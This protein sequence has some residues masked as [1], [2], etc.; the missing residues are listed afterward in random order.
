MLFSDVPSKP[1]YDTILTPL[2]SKFTKSGILSRI[3]LKSRASILPVS[4]RLV[5][6]LKN[7]LAKI[8]NVP[9]VVTFIS[10][11]PRG[12]VVNDISLP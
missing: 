1:K 7:E 3:V 8:D 4:V 9:G 10:L 11:T 6:V 12:F 2:I 5:T